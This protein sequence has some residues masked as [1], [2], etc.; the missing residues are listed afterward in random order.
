IRNPLFE[1]THEH[2]P[3]FTVQTITESGRLPYVADNPDGWMGQ[4]AAQPPLYYVLGALLISQI[5]T[6]QARNQ[7]WFNPFV[8]LGDAASPDN[9]N[10]FVH[11]PAE[12]WPWQGYALAAHMLRLLSTLLGLGTLVCIYGSARQARPDQPHLA[13]TAVALVAFLPQF[14]CLHSAISND[15]L[16]VLMCAAVF[17]QLLYLWRHPVTTGR[18]LLLGVSVGLA[19]LSKT[20]GLLLLPYAA[21]WLLLLA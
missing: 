13:L 7:V 1:A 9:I 11:T 12:A 17:W 18:L 3:Y 14:A 16:V 2:L 6:S 10:A 4:E 20:A 5:D 21:L 15:P 19:M 8:R